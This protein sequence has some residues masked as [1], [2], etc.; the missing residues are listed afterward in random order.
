MSQ[1]IWSLS[2]RSAGAL[3]L[4]LL[5]AAGLGASLGVQAQARKDSR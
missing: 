4:S 5:V 2:R 3:S 1:S